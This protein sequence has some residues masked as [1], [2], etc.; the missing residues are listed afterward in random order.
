MGS[1]KALD[2]T[3]VVLSVL[4]VEASSVLVTVRQAATGA[5]VVC[6]LMAV[7]MV[8]MAL[9]RTSLEKRIDEQGTQQG[10]MGIR[11]LGFEN[12]LILDAAGGQA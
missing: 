2:S 8:L 10:Q 12:G 3:N 7:G 4:G 6:M 1:N 11:V 5:V 9:G